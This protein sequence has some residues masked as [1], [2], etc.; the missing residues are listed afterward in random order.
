MGTE[1]LPLHVNWCFKIRKYSRNWS[2]RRGKEDGS[3]LYGGIYLYQ[4]SHMVRG[5]HIS[6]PWWK[7]LFQ[8]GTLKK[9]KNSHLYS[10][11]LET[12]PINIWASGKELSKS[13]C[14]RHS[15]LKPG[16]K[17]KTESWIFFNIFGKRLLKWKP[18]LTVQ[19]ETL[20]LEHVKYL[21][22]N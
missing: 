15:L 9:K 18:S 6:I 14:K 16:M 13:H 3:F 17:N 4:T 5:W 2:G 11:A 1:S 20:L 19:L 21:Q 22:Q 8:I 10:W 12:V 7:G